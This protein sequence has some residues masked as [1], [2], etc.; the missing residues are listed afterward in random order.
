MPYNFQGLLVELFR[1]YHVPCTLVHIKINVRSWVTWKIYQRTYHTH[2]IKCI[3][4]CRT[5]LIL[6]EIPISQFSPSRPT[7]LMTQSVKPICEQL[8]SWVFIFLNMSTPQN[9]F[10]SSFWY[11]STS[12]YLDIYIASMIHLSII[13]IK[14]PQM[15]WWQHTIQ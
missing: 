11:T 5:I 7:S 12:W 8:I 14:H 1:V 3:W 10:A 2:I 15:W 9:T 4:A 13:T 6:R